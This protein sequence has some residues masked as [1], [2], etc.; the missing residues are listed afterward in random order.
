ML[1]AP[2]QAYFD[3]LRQQHF[4]P[5]RNF[6]AAHLTLFHHLPGDAEAAIA[7]HVAAVCRHQSPL[8]LAVTGLR[9]LGRGVAFALD[10]PDLR[11]LH[12]QLQAHWQPWL[13]PQ[14]Q[15]R[16]APHVTIQNKV[17]PAEARQLLVRLT[18]EF[19]PFEA[20]G[21]GLQLWEYQGGPWESR[22]TFAFAAGS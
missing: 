9:S 1:D 19:R 7:G 17:D 6:L 18:D 3:G 20:L 14:D 2:S 4:P 22:R 16:L 11:T 13:T 10:N 21:T 8:P 12:R 15:Q 5:G